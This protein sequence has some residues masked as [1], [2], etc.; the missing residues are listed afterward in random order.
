MPATAVYGFGNP[1]VDVSL[2]VTDEDLAALKLEKGTMLLVDQDRQQQILDRVG[3]KEAT[4]LP[5]GSCPNTAV[6]LASLGT[7][8]ALAGGIGA[9][10]LGDVYGLRLAETGVVDRLAKVPGAATGTSIVLV[11]PDGER[12]MCTH[13]GACQSF[14]PGH[15]T[16][17]EITAAHYLYFT[18]YMLDT[19]N[20]QAAVQE[21]IAAA[22]SSGTRIVF[23]VADPFAVDRHAGKI[24]GLLDDRS[25][26]V[27]FANSEEARMLCGEP[28]P[29]QSAITLRDRLPEESGLS[30]VKDGAN[31]SVVA[32]AGYSRHVS[33]SRANVADTTGAGDAY[34]GAFMHALRKGFEPDACARFAGFMAARVV[35][36]RGAQLRSE[37]AVRYAREGAELV[38]VDAART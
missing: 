25:I 8:V 1:L 15:L 27:L 37:Q 34:A 29:Q 26:D 20:Q 11:T 19:P 23:D 28:D 13:L 35:E 33:A 2:G 10:K 30:V 36:V 9:D 38:S 3:E 22:R 17:A 31:G 16:R 32:A 12:T 5:G 4:Y 14:G 18:A 7:P 24:E 21:A 6:M